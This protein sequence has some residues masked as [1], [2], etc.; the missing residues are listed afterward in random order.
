MR[1]NLQ[2][3]DVHVEHLYILQSPILGLEVQLRG[4]VVAEVVLDE[5][6]G[7]RGFGEELVVGHGEAKCVTTLDGVDV[8]RSP[9]WTNNGVHAALDQRTLSIE[10]VD[11]KGTLVC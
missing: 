9:A 7:T 1:E 8:G 2:I 3:V 6:R 5:G 11:S 4:P 10:M